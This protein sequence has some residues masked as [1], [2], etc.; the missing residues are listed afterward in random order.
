MHLEKKTPI[1]SVD[2]IV[3]KGNKIL[4]GKLGEKWRENGK[5]EWGLPGREILFGDDFEE[6]VK[7]NMKEELGIEPKKFIVLCVNNN[8]GF[9]NHY[10]V[11]GILVEAIGEPKIMKPEDWAKWKWFGKKDIPE[12]LFPSAKLTL[13][14]FLEGKTFTK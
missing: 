2:L 10:V 12:K 6:T 5:F 3:T 13:Q 8:F 1:V 4:L 14:C 9:G 11:I 7:K